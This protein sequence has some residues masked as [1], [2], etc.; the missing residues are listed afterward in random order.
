[1]A[2]GRPESGP[3]LLAVVPLRDEALSVS[4]VWGKSFQSGNKTFGHVLDPRTGYPAS[5]AL[6]AA[7]VS[8]SATETDALSTALL[9]D[10][11]KGHGRI[12]ALRPGLRTLVLESFEGKM[13][14]QGINTRARAK[15]KS[16]R[17]EKQR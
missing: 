3:E 2:P 5:R 9:T 16:V 11:I 14:S 8:P 6:M 12:S 7:V 1:M 13:K 17:R 15:K 4:A 10:G